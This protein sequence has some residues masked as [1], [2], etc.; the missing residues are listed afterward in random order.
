M[1]F[2]VQFPSAELTPWDFRFLWGDFTYGMETYDM[3]GSVR[4]HVASWRGELFTLETF[5]NRLKDSRGE[6][7]WNCS[8]Y[9]VWAWSLRISN[10]HFCHCIAYSSETH[11]IFRLQVLIVIWEHFSPEPG[12]Y[13][14]V[15]GIC[16][17]FFLLLQSSFS[18]K[19]LRVK[20]LWK[21]V[22]I[23]LLY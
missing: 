5:E 16:R 23:T 12:G 1:Y 4:E 15:G 18:W 21:I 2:S 22:I 17:A 9:G 10:L 14:T 3:G 13:Q 8:S 6:R 20:V 11:L 7:F 19:N